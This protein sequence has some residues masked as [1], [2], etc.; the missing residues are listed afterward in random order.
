M[1]QNYVWI[2]ANPILDFVG[3]NPRYSRGDLM[4]L[5]LDLLPSENMQIYNRAKAK[6]IPECLLS[7]LFFGASHHSRWMAL[8]L[9]GSL[10]LCLRWWGTGA[11]SS[12]YEGQCPHVG[13]SVQPYSGGKEGKQKAGSGNCHPGWTIFICWSEHPI[14]GSWHSCDLPQAA[15]IQKKNGIWGFLS[16]KCS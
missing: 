13:V 14:S 4:F 3:R 1:F 5:T 6:A 12:C 9:L 8:L 7:P 2:L 15:L 16:L 10:S 11:S